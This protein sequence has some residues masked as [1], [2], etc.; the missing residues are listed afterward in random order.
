[1][2]IL[3]WYI[4]KRLLTSFFFVVLLIVAVFVV[5]DITEKNDDFIKNN[6]PL[7]KIIGVYYINYIPYTANMISPLLIFIA[8][9]FM[10]AN[11]ASHTEIIAML[12]SGMSFKRFLV[13]YFIGSVMIGILTFFLIGW[14]IP[15]SNKV[16]IE[17]ENQYIKEKFYFNQRNVHIKISANTYAYMES[18]NNISNTGY[19]FS[20]ETIEGTVLKSKL[21]AD[22]ITWNEEKK[23]WFL[24]FYQIRKFDGLEEKIIQGN[25]LDTLI[26][27]SPKDF[28]S[29]YSLEQTMNMGEL[30]NFITQQKER[31]AEDLETY[32]LEKYS[33]YAYPFAIIILTII[34]AIVSARKARGGVGFQIAFGFLLAFVY[35][36]FLI[37]SRSISQVGG[38]GPL[39]A[40]WLPNII[41]S[42]IGLIMYKTVPR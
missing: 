18:Y 32:L 26:S 9:V 7:G 12:S 33:R 4:L 27:L 2:K 42:F 30:E 1:M 34:G 16:R 6:V 24:D 28:G 37:M 13:P 14:I 15:E 3:D 22:K 36:L 23:T 25:N 19:L 20:L 38:I 10:T 39:L 29:T 35:L 8:T 5:I 40:V 21:K 41:F 31:G 17:F 11:L